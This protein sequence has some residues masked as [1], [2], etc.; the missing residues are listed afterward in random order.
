MIGHESHNLSNQAAIYK[1]GKALKTMITL[2]L[3]LE[4]TDKVIL[5]GHSMGGLSI[6]EYLQ[7]TDDGTTGTPH[8][9]WV[10][11]ND[12]IG[13]KVAKV[14][15]TGTPHG[16]SNYLNLLQSL[17]PDPNSEAIRDLR[18]KYLSYLSEPPDPSTD[19]GVYLFGGTETFNDMHTQGFYNYDINC[20]GD[21]IDQIYG[22][23][24]WISQAGK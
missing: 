17:I 7:R 12:S 23:N 16:G 1:Q 4:N 19:N 11:P 20:D 9:W 15:T 21:E 2:V 10:D 18:Y 5:I 22:I 13:H 14:V 24:S 3:S 8:T 6:R